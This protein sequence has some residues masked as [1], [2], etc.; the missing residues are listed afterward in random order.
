MIIINQRKL[1]VLV[2]PDLYADFDAN[3]HKILLILLSFVFGLSRSALSLFHDS[4]CH[5]II[6]VLKTIDT[7]LKKL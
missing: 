4:Y 1:S 3:D 5:A 2:L 7:I 6:F